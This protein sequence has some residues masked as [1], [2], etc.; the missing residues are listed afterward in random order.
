MTGSHS[1]RR[2]S[3]L[4]EKNSRYQDHLKKGKTTK[5]ARQLAVEETVEHLGHSR[6]RRDLAAAYLGKRG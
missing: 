4:E 3:A 5:K 2:A 6:N 1:H